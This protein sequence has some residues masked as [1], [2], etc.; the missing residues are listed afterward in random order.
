MLKSA[1][2]VF[3]IALSA[4]YT[5]LAHILNQ[6]RKS[7]GE[8]LKIPI[9]LYSP[10]PGVESTLKVTWDNEV[11]ANVKQ[12]FYCLVVNAEKWQYKEIVFSFE[13]YITWY[14]RPDGVQEGKGNGN[15]LKH[16]ISYH[17]FTVWRGGYLDGFLYPGRWLCLIS[18]FRLHSSSFP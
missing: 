8:H 1:S 12:A 6:S 4:L 13:F 18:L 2:L 11:N 17:N 3:H 14:H 15:L 9:M 10:R 5:L 16:K 7:I